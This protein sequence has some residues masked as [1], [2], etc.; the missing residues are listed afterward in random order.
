MTVPFAAILPVWKSADTVS[1]VLKLLFIRH[2]KICQRGEF[3]LLQYL[4]STDHAYHERRVAFIPMQIGDHVFI[5]EGSTISATQVGSYVLIGKN[6][7]IGRN[8]ILKDCCVINDGTV[9]PPGT[10]VA[11]FAV[12]SGSPATITDEAPECMQ[13]LMINYTK[14]YYEHF[15]PS[16]A[17][18]TAK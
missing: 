8:C 10:T 16:P 9:V 12:M 11:A 17:M 2:L 7:T 1:L 13:D 18:T 4:T 5:G 14:D 3:I 15:K 6:C